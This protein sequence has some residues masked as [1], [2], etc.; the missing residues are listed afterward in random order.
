MKKIEFTTN[1]LQ[2]SVLLATVL[3]CSSSNNSTQPKQYWDNLFLRVHKTELILH[4]RTFMV[5]LLA[6]SKNVN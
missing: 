1:V 2:P 6:R 4:L 3:T 5:T